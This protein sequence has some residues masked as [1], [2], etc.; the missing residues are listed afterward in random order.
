MVHV[1]TAFAP[2]GTTS[3]ISARTYYNFVLRLVV[4]VGIGFVVPVLLVLLNFAGLVSA[5]AI[6][7][8]WRMALL[9]IA[10]FCAIATPPS[11][12]LS[13]FV[14]AVPMVALY[15]IAAAIAWVHD[16]RAKKKLDSYEAAFM[17]NL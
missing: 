17:E 11:D 5:K 6:L 13:M 15:Y 12:V 4:V 10:V 8:S 1:L 16:R 9:V 3:V 7:K 2:E 14:L